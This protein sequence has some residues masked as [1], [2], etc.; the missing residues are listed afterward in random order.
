MP[1][2]DSMRRVLPGGI[3]CAARRSRAELYEA[4]RRLPEMPRTTI[5]ET[6]RERR[7]REKSDR[8]SVSCPH[9]IPSIRAASAL[10][11]LLLRLQRRQQRRLDVLPAWVHLQRF[12]PGGAS[13]VDIA[14]LLA[15]HAEPHERIRVTPRGPGRARLLSRELFGRTRQGLGALFG[16]AAERGGSIQQRDAFEHQDARIIGLCGLGA[17]EGAVR[18]RSE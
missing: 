17:F 16:A 13:A 1:A 12:F 14:E 10:T 7:G 8:A 5:V 11:G 15:R 3:D 18:A 4:R 6:P 2:I 9:R